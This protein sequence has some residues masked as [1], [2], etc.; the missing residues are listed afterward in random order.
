MRVNAQQA[1]HLVTTGRAIVEEKRGKLVE[2]IRLTLCNLAS[3]QLGCRPGSFGIRRES[4]ECG[5][6]IFQH[7]GTWPRLLE[8]RA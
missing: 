7:K 5:G 1:A 6:Q 2:R 3:H 4:L 8:A